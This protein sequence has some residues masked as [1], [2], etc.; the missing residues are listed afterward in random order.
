MIAS[1][2]SVSRTQR[3]RPQLWL[4]WVVLVAGTGSWIALA[5]DSSVALPVGLSAIIAVGSGLI[6]G[7]SLAFICFT[8][9]AIANTPC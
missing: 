7:M 3:Y 4:G 1:G 6:Y 8:R 9:R 5:A 2:L